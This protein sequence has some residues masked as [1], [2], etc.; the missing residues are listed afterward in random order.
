MA[1][2]RDVARRAR[3][4]TASVSRVLN[5]DPAVNDGTKQKVLGAIRDLN[6][7]PNRVA[8]SLRQ[9]S[10]HIIALVLDSVANPYFAEIAKGVED[11]VRPAGYDLFLYAT[12]QDHHKGVAY[13]ETMSNRMVDGI[14]FSASGLDVADAL[15]ER[16]ATLSQLN[17]PTVMVGWQLPGVPSVVAD[18]YDGSKQAVRHLT[19]LGHR[20]IAFL[21]GPPGSAATDERLRGFADGMRELGCHIPDGYVLCAHC[22]TDDA[23]AATVG[24]LAMDHPPTA[25]F[26]A[27]DL[28]AL[29]AMHAAHERGLALP[30]HL[31]VIGFDNVGFTAYTNPALTTVDVPKQE[32]GATAARLLLHHLASNG[33][34]STCAEVL[35]TRLVERKSCAPPVAVSAA[36]KKPGPTL[37]LLTP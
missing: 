19:S 30:E 15:A 23:A 12:N 29:G 7:R 2:L 21:S 28:M 35:G 4:S 31:S 37:H 9:R 18:C 3:V 10:T 6:Y 32:L 8:R 22:R 27:N 24:L 36:W 33:A 13:L 26:C 11:F 5:G 34:P 14:V 25:I 1:T 16:I 20:R 17:I